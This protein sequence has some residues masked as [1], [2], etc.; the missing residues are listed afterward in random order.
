M[1][2]QIEAFLSS[3]HWFI[4]GLIVV[5]FSIFVAFMYLVVGAVYTRLCILLDIH[6]CGAWREP[7]HAI[8]D[9]RDDKHWLVRDALRAPDEAIVRIVCWP[10]MIAY[11][12]MTWF[13]RVVVSIAIPKARKYGID[14]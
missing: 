11:D 14:H 8:H 6:G 12:M 3:F 10:F 9:E 5:G 7:Y 13:F 2:E 1:F 4:A